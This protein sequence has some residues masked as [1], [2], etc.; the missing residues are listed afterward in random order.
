MVFSHIFYHFRKFPNTGCY[1]CHVYRCFCSPVHL[2]GTNRWFNIRLDVLNMAKIE[3]I[4]NHLTWRHKYICGSISLTT[5]QT[6]KIFRFIFEKKQHISYQ[7][8]YFWN[9]CCFG[10]NNRKCGTARPA[11]HRRS[12]YVAKKTRFACRLF[13]TKIQTIDHNI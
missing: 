3:K 7:T 8:H 1:L 12:W 2:H 9:P 6:E 5:S 13:K 11:I 4:V 10:N